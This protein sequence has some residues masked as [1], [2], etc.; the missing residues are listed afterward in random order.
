MLNSSAEHEMQIYLLRMR[1]DFRCELCHHIMKKSIFG[2]ATILLLLCATP[3]CDARQ[4]GLYVMFPGCVWL[5][6]A[7]PER[8]PPGQAHH[9]E[10]FGEGGAVCAARYADSYIDER[11]LHPSWCFMSSPSLAARIRFMD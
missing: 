2:Y 3:T 10:D 8:A 7:E 11:N 1:V 5:S 9:V 6:T 4:W